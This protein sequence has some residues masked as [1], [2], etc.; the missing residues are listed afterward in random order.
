M[1]MN[2]AHEY[3]ARRRPGTDPDPASSS[4]VMR[5]AAS[6]HEAAASLQ[7]D[8]GLPLGEATRPAAM[9]GQLSF[10][11]GVPNMARIYDALLGGKDNY[12]ADRRAADEVVRLRPQV[13]AGARANRAF[14]ARAV[15]FLAAECGIRQFLDIGTGLPAP[16]STHQVAQSVDPACRV[17]Y[18]DTDPVVLTH[19]RA[20][21]VSAPEG[22]CGYVDA[23]V[24]DTT[25]VLAGVARTLDLAQPVAVLL[26][27]ILHFVPDA[28][29]PGA[30]VAKVTAGL[31]SGSY[32]AISHLTGDFAP[33]PVA[34]AI[35]AYNDLASVPVTARTHAQVAGL[36]G[37]LPLVTPGVV[38]VAEWPTTTLLP[39][40]MTAD[41]YAGL[42]RIPEGHR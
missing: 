35:A 40:R 27:A 41:L 21:L 32:V 6:D 42:A 22:V 24:R 30:V 3:Q 5:F 16:D 12:E 13:V 25:A 18:V 19:A 2:T 1:L 4:P 17:V 34:A 26:L 9:L 38:P 8:P 23:D 28:D 29:D 15:R 36:F 31:A 39:H 7:V 20:L 33:E 37:G 11:P 10:E 14:L